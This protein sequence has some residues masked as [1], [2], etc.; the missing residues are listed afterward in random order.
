L[1][2]GGERAVKW[3]PD[4]LIIL[5]PNYLKYNPLSNPN[6][7]RSWV[8]VIDSIPENCPLIPQW[9]SLTDRFIKQYHKRFLY[10]FREL[11]AKRFGEPL[12]PETGSG[13]TVGERDTRSRSSNRSR[14]RSDGNES[15]GINRRIWDL[16]VSKYETVKRS[17]PTKSEQFRRQDLPKLI[18][19][20][21]HPAKI[22][23]AEATDEQIEDLLG[24][25][26][27]IYFKST[28]EKIVRD[29][30]SLGRCVLEFTPLLEKLRAQ[31]K[32]RKGK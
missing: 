26:F 11:F 31:R 2:K 30:H 24:Q 5:L 15:N 9:Y 17:F 23:G 19:A 13:V 10:L 1:I 22:R 28:D 20:A 4:N 16:Y 32:R 3:D 8:R 6:L 21:R 7:I 18:S 12:P 14:I 25:I 29:D 27:D